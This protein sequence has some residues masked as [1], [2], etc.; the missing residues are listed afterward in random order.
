VSKL[1]FSRIEPDH[2][3]NWVNLEEADWSNLIAVADK[4]AKSAK[5]KAQETAIFRLFSFGL[6]TNR[7]DWVYSRKR[8][9]ISAKVELLREIYETDRC[10]VPTNEKGKRDA[11]KID[12]SMK[13][14]RSVKR[15]LEKNSVLDY[16]KSCFVECLYRPFDKQ[17]L[18]FLPSLIEMLNLTREMFGKQACNRNPC[19]V[20]SDPTSQ[21][22][23]MMT[24]TECVFDMHLVGA[25]S[26]AAGLPRY[27][28]GKQE[29][30]IDNITDWGLRLY[31]NSNHLTV[32]ARG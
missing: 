14:T 15:Q 21:K 31:K 30:R 7:D 4:R 6:V 27:R 13:W 1:T 17:S 11:S 8:S 20:F 18:F 29:E 16:S 2:R 28:L 9:E 3:G 19:I 25:A 12:T 32:A 22:P 24:A 23:F 5:T 10:R 26:G